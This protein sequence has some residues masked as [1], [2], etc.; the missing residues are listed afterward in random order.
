MFSFVYILFFNGQMEYPHIHFR[1][2]RTFAPG[3]FMR[4]LVFKLRYDFGF[5]MMI[6]CVVELR[7]DASF[8]FKKEIPHST[9]FHSE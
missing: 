7:K 9:A 5:E 3:Y 2:A 8:H 1:L 6:R 4:I